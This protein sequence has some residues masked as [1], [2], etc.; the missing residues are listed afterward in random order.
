M[1]AAHS[2]CHRMLLLNEQGVRCDML[3]ESG[4]GGREE[5]TPSAKQLGVQPISQGCQYAVQ[6]INCECSSCI[7]SLKPIALM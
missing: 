2:S 5:V 6:N 7:N 3:N 1:V 4:G